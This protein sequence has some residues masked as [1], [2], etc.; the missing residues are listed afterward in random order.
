M[1]APFLRLDP[2]HEI[3]A[4]NAPYL[5]DPEGWQGFAP[6]Q[7]GNLLFADAENGCHFFGSQ[8]LVL[9]LHKCRVHEIISLFAM[10][11]WV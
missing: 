10:I 2:C 11:E 7:G 1:C 8:E 5:P 4:M 3:G 9:Y 6:R